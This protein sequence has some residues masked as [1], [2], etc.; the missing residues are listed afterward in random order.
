MFHS[1]ARLLYEGPRHLC[2]TL[3]FLDLWFFSQF[4]YLLIPI[5]SL[6]PAMQFLFS[7]RFRKGVGS[8]KIAKR[9][10]KI[11]VEAG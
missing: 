1:Y 7:F 9:V 10:H 6:S 5:P 3:L 11:K 8:T 2:A 4:Q